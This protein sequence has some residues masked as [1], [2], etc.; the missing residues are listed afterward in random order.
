M[1]GK[2]HRPILQ[3]KA[4]E[5]HGLLNCAV[6]LLRRHA[7]TVGAIAEEAALERML[8]LEA[9]LAAQRFNN[10]MSAAGRVLSAAELD[11]MLLNYNHFAIL[12]DRAGGHITPK[13]HLMFHGLQRTAT[14]GNL[15]FYTTYRDESLNGVIARIARSCHR[16]SWH[17]M[18]HY[19]V[20]YMLATQGL[21]LDVWEV[22]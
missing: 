20:N 5:T 14:H 18:V 11:S 15:R 6:D 8:L 12:F 2:R 22:H 4:A 3:A 19:K 10:M 16:R 7:E 21:A 9:G 17:K 13:F 1:I